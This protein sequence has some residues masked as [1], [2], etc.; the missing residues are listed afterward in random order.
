MIKMEKKKSTTR[1]LQR[2]LPLKRL[3]CRSSVLSGA[4]VFSPFRKASP[5][6]AWRV[7][8]L[9]S[10]NTYQRKHYQDQNQC[11]AHLPL[12]VIFNTNN[13]HLSSRIICSANNVIIVSKLRLQ[14]P[15]RF[16]RWLRRNHQ[17]YEIV[18]VPTFLPFVP[19]AFPLWDTLGS[20]AK[21]LIFSHT[22]TVQCFIILCVISWRPASDLATTAA[23]SQEMMK[24]E[25][26]SQPLI[27][28]PDHLNS[29]LPT[30]PISKDRCLR[31][32]LRSLCG[33]SA[34]YA[35]VAGRTRM[36]AAW[37]NMSSIVF[38]ISI[39]GGGPLQQE[40]SLPVIYCI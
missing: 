38:H 31:T 28:R 27:I 7:N 18:G 39:K 5:M 23:T 10:W 40:L 9:K 1:H 13:V 11:L 12:W 30:Y 25:T 15:W 8:L 32:G 20:V 33:K 6:C 19:H 29:R 34:V 17:S 16:V 14:L 21:S 36:A 22:V 37:R 3:C 4:T 26:T 35:R 2:I 24:L